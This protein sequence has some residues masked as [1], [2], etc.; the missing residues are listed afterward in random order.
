MKN[1]KT[2]SIKTTISAAVVVLTLA[3]F[4]ELTVCQFGGGGPMGGMEGR[5][6]M[7][8]RDDGQMK[9]MQEMCDKNPDVCNLM[10][11]TMTFCQENGDY[12]EMGGLPKMQ[13]PSGGMGGPGGGGPG[14]GGGPGGGGAPRIW[15]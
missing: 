12:C 11:E 2:G 4:T 1:R 7:R 14:M 10:K 6:G 5:G 9:K 15:A 3:V 8:S 13:K